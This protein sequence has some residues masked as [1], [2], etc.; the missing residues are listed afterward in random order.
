MSK[1]LW[2]HGP[3][4]CGKTVNGQRLARHFGLKRVIEFDTILPDGTPPGG[5]LI[6]SINPPGPAH[7]KRFDVLSFAEA[8][9][10]SGFARNPSGK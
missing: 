7:S 9:R 3:Q 1:G 5:A 4:G 10:L 6:L 2:I 8:M